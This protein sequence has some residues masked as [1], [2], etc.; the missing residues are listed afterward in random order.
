MTLENQQ[1]HNTETNSSQGS[2]KGYRIFKRGKWVKRSNGV[3]AWLSAETRTAISRRTAK[4]KPW[5]HAKHV[6][7][8]KLKIKVENTPTPTDTGTTVRLSQETATLVGNFM[9]EGVT[10]EETVEYLI[11]EGVFKN[12]ESN[13]K[14]KLSKILSVFEAL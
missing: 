9:G 13:P 2:T 1:I 4:T 5:N 11:R 8:N 12:K 3:K 6:K 14:A 7:K 10:F